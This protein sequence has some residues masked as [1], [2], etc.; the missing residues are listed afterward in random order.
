MNTC[1]HLRWM[2]TL[3]AALTAHAELVWLLS[4]RQF[5]STC[6]PPHN[7]AQHISQGR[8]QS[9][10]WRSTSWRSDSLNVC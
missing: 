10:S 8:Q 6:S 9:P 5:C 3:P 7:T 4:V 1:Q 2:H